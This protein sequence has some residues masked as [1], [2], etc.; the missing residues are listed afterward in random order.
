MGPNP[1]DYL[2][3][4]GVAF[5]VT[6]VFTPIAQRLAWRIGAVVAPDERRVHARPTPTLGGLAMLLGLLAGL[7][8]A[9]TR[10]GFA[11][12]FTDTSVPAGIVAA[13]VLIYAVG[14]VD[15]LR[16]VSAPGKLAGMV[17]AAMFL[18]LTGT[19]ILT[20]RVPRL[21]LLLVSDDLVPLLSVLW[22]IGIANAVNLIDGLDGLAAGV[23]AIAAGTFAVYGDVLMNADIIGEGNIG[24]LLASLACGMCLGFLPYNVHPARIFMGDGGALLLGLVMAA[25]TMAVGGSVDEPFS[26]QAFF[27]YAPLVIPLVILG[28]P[29]IDMAWAVVRRAARGG[30]V[31]RADKEHLHHRLM[32]LGH[33]QRRSVA[34]LWAWTGLLSAFVLYPTLADG[35][36][37]AV[38]PVGV[39]AIVLLLLTYFHP[40][41]RRVRQSAREDQRGQGADSSER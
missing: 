37:D 13:A 31:T 30:S 41:S 4:G 38:V 29:L 33:G 2:I 26:G 16:D 8:V 24:P 22:V 1:S 25:G 21:G 32:R 40:E 5:V 6:L 7:A 9:A 10:G 35:R 11:A 23:V 19:A 15:D 27:F 34:I 14:F 28:V 18:V 36:G 12:V 3:A 17:L 39:V 20:F